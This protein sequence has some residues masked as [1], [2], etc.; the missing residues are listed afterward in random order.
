MIS[1]IVIN[2]ELAQLRVIQMDSSR[3]P[4]LLKMSYKTAIMQVSQDLNQNVYFLLFF[5]EMLLT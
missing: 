2:T 4:P 3:F 5:K 1:K